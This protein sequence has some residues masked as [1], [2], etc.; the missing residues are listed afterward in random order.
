MV[1]DMSSHSSPPAPVRRSAP[2]TVDPRVAQRRREAKRK[3]L[4]RRRLTFLAILLFFLLAL[5]GL[6]F[7][8]VFAAKSCKNESDSLTPSLPPDSQQGQILDDSDKLPNSVSINGVD[9]SGKL[10]SEA[11]TIIASI[12][13]PSVAVTLSGEGINVSWNA[14]AIGA[15]WDADSALKAA[16]SGGQIQ[17]K[18]VYDP[19]RV[20]AALTELNQ[21]I[22]NHAVDAT[23][24]IQYDSNGAPEFVYHEGQ[25]GMQLDYEAIKAE[26]ALN[27][28]QGNYNMTI[29]PSV[30]VSAPAV[31]VESLKKNTTKLASYT[32]TYRFKG[33]S[34]MTQE[35]K[36]N[37]EARDANIRKASEM[38]HSI[39]LEPGQVFS[40]NDTTGNRSDWAQAKA[41]YI[42]GYRPEGGGGVC[43]VSTTMFN[44]LLRAN[45]EVV[46][47]KGHSIP[48]DYVTEKYVDG[49]GFDATVDYGH[50]DFKFRNN[51]DK[52]LYMFVY[53]TTNS[54]SSRKRDIHVELYGVSNGDNVEFRV[55]NEIVEQI[56]ADTPEY[57]QD[58]KQP[59]GYDVITKN[60]HDYYL[61]RSYVDKYVD[62]QRVETVLT[63][64][65]EYPLIQETHVVGIGGT[66]SPTPGG[67]TGDPD[68]TPK[69]DP[70][71]PE[72]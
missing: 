63:Y 27:M 50:I 69:D 14:E 64:E 55:R 59:A 34:S 36:D 62:G 13:P 20:D 53:V 15:S 65:T 54:K 57:I 24:E 18:V 48:S 25:Q 46:N 67:H 66:P 44:A 72:L 21:T 60:A 58:K 9:V 23:F 43:Q 35:E 71:I 29:T 10:V 16:M 2:S 7:A 22:P 70:G 49:L 37:C 47:R 45:I 56:I 8:I 19:A 52:P 26:I 17:L 33:T 1:R 40:F 68:P 3:A 41:V 11:K 5:V 42:G 39:T 30:T 61:I 4:M 31:T 38:M 51:T 12:P 32:T 6:I 28:E